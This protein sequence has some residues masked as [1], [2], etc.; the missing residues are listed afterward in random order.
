M[1][2]VAWGATCGITMTKIQDNIQIAA[3]PYRTGDN[4]SPVVMLVTSR[5]TRRWVI[6]KGWLIKGLTPRKAAMQEAYEEAGLV[7]RVIG[8]QPIGLFHYEK[9]LPENRMRCEV[10]VFLLH[11]DHQ[12]DD[13]PEKAQRQT[14]WFDPVEA[15]RLVDEKG[16]AE[17]I[18]QAILSPILSV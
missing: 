1:T 3:L 17:I 10:R 13:W 7:G 18:N 5:A 6:P 12:L 9:Q 14:R 4:G 15:A 16:L 11:V 2:Y 8:K